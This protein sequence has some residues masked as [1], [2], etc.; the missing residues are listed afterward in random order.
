M[1]RDRLLKESL[2]RISCLCRDYL[3]LGVLVDFKGRRLFSPIS[4]GPGSDGVFR[5][6][7]VNTRRRVLRIPAL[8]RAG[9]MKFSK[10]FEGL[11]LCG[12]DI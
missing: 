12:S 3:R 4:E 11:S 6:L 2:G 5:V 7:K 10:G 9:K 1:C 8:S